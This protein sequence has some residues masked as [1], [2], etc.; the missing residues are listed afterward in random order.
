[1]SDAIPLHAAVPIGSSKCLPSRQ[2]QAPQ[3]E[4]DSAEAKAIT[5]NAQ[6][7]SCLFSQ[8]CFGKSYTSLSS[9]A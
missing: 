5:T 7:M 9:A 2:K 4:L 8:I 6:R 3:E 1:M